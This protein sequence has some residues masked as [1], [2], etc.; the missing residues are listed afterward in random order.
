MK[1]VKEKRQFTV[2]AKMV[3][4]LESDQ[5]IHR[6]CHLKKL[7]RDRQMQDDPSIAHHSSGGLKISISGG[8]NL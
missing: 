5:L 6:R 1:A 2:V 4:G 8:V 7:W 3:L